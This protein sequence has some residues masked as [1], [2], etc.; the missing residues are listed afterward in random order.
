MARHRPSA[1]AIPPQTHAATAAAQVH[2]DIRRK[3][4]V[5]RINE[6]PL[7]VWAAMRHRAL[8]PRDG[9]QTHYDHQRK[10][11]TADTERRTTASTA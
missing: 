11:S 9:T 5:H 2:N 6:A 1:T 8:H 10:R 3:E 4:E 7:Q